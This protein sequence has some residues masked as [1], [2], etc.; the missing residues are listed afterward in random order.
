MKYKTQQ[1]LQ[2]FGYELVFDTIKEIVY[3]NE[4]QKC[5]LTFN[6]ETK[7]TIFSKEQ[8]AFKQDFLR[9]LKKQWQ[10]VGL[11]KK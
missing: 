7:E 4:K 11:W 9:S 6:L 8:V 1:E 5:Y 2:R 10:E 3:F